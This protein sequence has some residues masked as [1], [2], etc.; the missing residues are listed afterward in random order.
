MS[1]PCLQ[2]IHCS[3][4]VQPGARRRQNG[5]SFRPLVIEGG[6]RSVP[7]AHSWQAALELFDLSLLVFYQSYLVFW[8]ANMNVLN[9]S[10]WPDPE[11]TG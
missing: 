5:R 3:D 7:G 2:L 10:Y 4:G 8:E 11:K 9:G 1:K 6:A